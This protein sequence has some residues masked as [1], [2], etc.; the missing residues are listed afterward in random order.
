MRELDRNKKT[1]YYA[2]FESEEEEMRNGLYT[3]GKTKLYGPVVKT[4]MGTS[5]ARTACGFVSSVTQMEFFGIDKPYSKTMWTSDINCPIT[6]ETIVWLDQGTLAKYD[7]EKSY[8]AGA[9]CIHEGKI[10]KCA[11][12]TVA[13]EFDPSVW[14][15]VIHTHIV[16]GISK[17]LNF[18]VYALKE[19]DFR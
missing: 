3:G 10:Y 17:S 16:T 12:D 6:E 8:T 7:S 9:K 19:V 14:N 4:K 13:G 1:I 18:I 2:L 11:E 15:A 5:G